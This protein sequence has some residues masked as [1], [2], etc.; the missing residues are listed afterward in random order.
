MILLVICG[1]AQIMSNY[2]RDVAQQTENY[3]ESPPPSPCKLTR[4]T[5]GRMQV[6]ETNTWTTA[7]C[8]FCHMPF[9]CDVSY[10][11]ACYNCYKN[12]VKKCGCGRNIKLNAHAYQDKCTDCWLSARSLTHERCPSCV[13]PKAM[14]LRKKIGYDCCAD[15]QDRKKKKNV[16]TGVPHIKR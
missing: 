12:Y 11:T 3:D 8:I 4:E 10:K 6:D 1:Y 14:H 9:E 13:G 2:K 7:V 16:A 5:T 15:C